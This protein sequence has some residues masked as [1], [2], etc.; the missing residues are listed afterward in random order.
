MSKQRRISKFSAEPRNS[1]RWSEEIPE[2][3]VEEDSTARSGRSARSRVLETSVKSDPSGV[4]GRWVNKSTRSETR[5]FPNREEHGHRTFRNLIR[6]VG[7][8]TCHGSGHLSLENLLHFRSEMKR[9]KGTHFKSACNSYSSFDLLT[10][11]NLLDHDLL[12]STEMTCLH[13]YI[14]RFA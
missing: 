1:T 3:P 4:A 7:I 10:V 14:I 8:K 6:S 13:P 2:K 5:S 9:K 11:Y 12:I